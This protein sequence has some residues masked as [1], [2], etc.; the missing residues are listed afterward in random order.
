MLRGVAR[1]AAILLLCAIGRATA[2]GMQPPHITRV[3]VDWAAATEQLGPVVTARAIHA[4]TEAPTKG[5]ALDELNTAVADRLPDVAR[6]PVP[7]LLPFDVDGYLRDRSQDEPA[8]LA[9]SSAPPVPPSRSIAPARTI[10]LNAIA[11]AIDPSRDPDQARFFGF[12]HPAFF[13]AGPAGYD[14]TFRFA[15]ADIPELADIRF[16]GTADVAISAS[17]LIYDVAVPLADQG[18]SVAAL[19]ADFPGI[20]RSLVE[21][22]LRYTFVRYG[23]PYVV[24]TD[25]FDAAVGRYHHMACRDA[26]RVIQLFLHK[27]RIVGGAPQAQP[28][29]VTPPALERPAAASPTFTYYA[30][31][32]LVPTTGYRGHAGSADDTV[33][34]NIRFPIAEAP[35]FANT[36]FY[37]RRVPGGIHAY[38]WRDNFC[39]SRSFYLSQCPGGMGHQGQ[40]I[41]AAN[42]NS[43]SLGDDRCSEHQNDVLAVRDGAILRAPGQEAVWLFVNTANEHIRFRY[44][45]M[46]P[47]LLDAAAVFSGR[48]VKAGELIGQVGTYSGHENGTS[49]HLHFDVQVPT[50][51][52]WI[53]VNPYMTLVAA[54]ERLIGGRGTAISDDMLASAAT[55]LN[56]AGPPRTVTIASIRDAIFGPGAERASSFDA[57]GSHWRHRAA[58]APCGRHWRRCVTHV[59]HHVHGIRA[60]ATAWRYRRH[61]G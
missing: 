30:P 9:R 46:R 15:L 61:H 28:Q 18:A 32:H 19:E 27:L 54:Y 55:T 6:S 41:G 36:Q 45:H 43:A 31:G 37:A 17:Q 20:R 11:G 5:S 1:V 59:A 16:G 58:A 48:T 40:D 60:R 14:A 4:S 22:Y 12:G 47:K 35:A 44:L 34:A 3:A 25:C 39:E 51:W 24:S 10:V 38:P 42:C 7:V 53:Y 21:D 57:P 23:V 26:D 56:D 49:Y 2:G 50:R 52:G 8:P 33:Y 13:D 29:P